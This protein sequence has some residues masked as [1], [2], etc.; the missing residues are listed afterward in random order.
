[1]KVN[2]FYLSHSLEAMTRVWLILL[3]INFKIFHSRSLLN[4]L[5]RILVEYDVKLSR[6]FS[7][8]KGVEVFYQKLS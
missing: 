3:I 6:V 2:F 5:N 8:N 4:I 1:M 7:L